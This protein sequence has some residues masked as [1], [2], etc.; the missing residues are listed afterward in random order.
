MLTLEESDEDLEQAERRAMDM[1]RESLRMDGVG[2]EVMN[3]NPF[4]FNGMGHYG[5]LD[6]DDEDC[7]SDG[8]SRLRPGS[9]GSGSGS[10]PPIPMSL[11]IQ[12]Q[13][14][15]S[16]NPMIFDPTSA[17]LQA[18]HT[19]QAG[20]N[21]YPNFDLPQ[22]I[23]ITNIPQPLSHEKLAAWNAPMF[24]NLA[25]N[26]WGVQ[27]QQPSYQ[28]MAANNAQAMF[29]PPVSAN[30]M[31]GFLGFEEATPSA[32]A[33]NRSASLQVGLHHGSVT[34]PT[35]APATTYADT[36][37]AFADAYGASVNVGTNAWKNGKVDAGLT[38]VT[39]G[40]GGGSVGLHYGAA[41]GVFM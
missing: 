18:H 8:Q 41:M 33:R 28:T 30:G 16:S 3:G 19:R 24:N 12:S 23:G 20:I 11:P 10:I 2:P 27:Q 17:L 26:Q 15:A 29:T 4:A 36:A 5:G 39:S 9:Q 25:Q 35:S 37:D 1:V 13:N 34:P 21:S 38:N 32:A 7:S 31:S 14:T 22:A 40:N 6:E